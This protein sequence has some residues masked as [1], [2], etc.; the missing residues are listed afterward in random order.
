[1]GILEVVQEPGLQE[2]VRSLAA[3]IQNDIERFCG[4]AVF[5]GLRSQGEADEMGPAPI[6]IR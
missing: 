1:M 3:R 5:S 2:V 6:M 4:E